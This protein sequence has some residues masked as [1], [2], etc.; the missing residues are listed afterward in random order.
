MQ[1]K[2]DFPLSI[3]PADGRLD[4]ERVSGMILEAFD[5]WLNPDDRAYLEEMQ[6]DGAWMRQH[7]FLS[8]IRGERYPLEGLV[9]LSDEGKIIGNLGLFHNDSE[10]DRPA[11]QFANICVDPQYRGRG[12]GHKLV[13]A[14]LRDCEAKG[15]RCVTL[16]VREQTPDAVRLYRDCGFEETLSRDCWLC[17]GGT[18]GTPTGVLQTGIP[19][20]SEK[21]AFREAFA[22]AYPPAFQKTKDMDVTD[23]H[24]GSPGALLYLVTGGSFLFRT[25]PGASGPIAW[26]GIRKGQGFADELLFLSAPNSCKEEI[27]DA[28]QQIASQYAVGKALQCEVPK[29]LYT[30][31]F[32]DAGFTLRQQILSMKRNL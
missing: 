31:A 14:A 7:P 22:A 4:L 1:V 28:L 8:R 10:A 9:C 29:G 23:F 25:V 2:T 20:L 17:R 5:A 30:E 18:I 15:I 24:F 11:I 26:F 6:A 19:S 21:K 12:I 3:R 32:A 27:S 16:Q 13:N